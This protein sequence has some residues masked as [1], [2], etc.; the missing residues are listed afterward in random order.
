M[1]DAGSH[2]PK[3]I[4][5]YSRILKISP[6]IPNMAFAESGGENLF[7]APQVPWKQLVNPK[8]DQGKFWGVSGTTI[9]GIP[10][11]PPKLGGRGCVLSHFPPLPSQIPQNGHFLPQITPLA[12]VLTT[13]SL[14]SK[15]KKK[16]GRNPT[17]K[18]P[19]LSSPVLLIIVIILNYS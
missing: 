11:V 7:C 1:T 14:L 19:T 16:K 3:S 9:P 5:F 10:L 18:T 4:Y 17:S 6:K 13:W 12:G 15:K 2:G 8:T